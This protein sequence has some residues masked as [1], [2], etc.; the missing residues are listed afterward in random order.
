VPSSVDRRDLLL[1]VLKVDRTLRLEPLLPLLPSL[2]LRVKIR[3]LAEYGRASAEA[4]L[5]VATGDDAVDAVAVVPEGNGV[6]RP[7]PTDL[8]V[9]GKTKGG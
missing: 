6:F 8:M 3:T 2:A 9:C 4:R 7:T 5:L 1:D